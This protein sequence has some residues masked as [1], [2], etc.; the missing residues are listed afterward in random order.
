M[1]VTKH[2]QDADRLP[3]LLGLAA[4]V[5]LLGLDVDVDARIGRQRV[6]DGLQVVR[7]PRAAARTAL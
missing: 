6:L 1:T 4:E 3:E 7:H 5:L 2:G